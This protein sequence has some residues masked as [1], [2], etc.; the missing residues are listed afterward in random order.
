[1]ILISP[2]L[3]AISTNIVTLSVFYLMELRK[4]IYLNQIVFYLQ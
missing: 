2:L 3:L 1:M 4:Y